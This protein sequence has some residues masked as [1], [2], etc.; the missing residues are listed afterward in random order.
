[1]R[2][3]EMVAKHVLPQDGRLGEVDIKRVLG[4]GGV[5]TAFLQKALTLPAICTLKKIV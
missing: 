5:T 3:C 1:M 2:Q 4:A